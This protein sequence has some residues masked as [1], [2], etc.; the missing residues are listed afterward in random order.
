MATYTLI[1]SYTVGSGGVSD[2]TFSSIPATYTDLYLNISARGSLASAFYGMNLT[3]NGSA[4]SFTGKQLEGSGAAAS[5]ASVTR[6]I[7]THNGNGST[8]STFSNAGVYFTNYASS[9]LNKSYSVDSASETNATT[10][11]VDLQ[12]GL[13]SNTAA[14]TSLSVAM[15]AGNIVEFSSFY[16]YGIK[17]S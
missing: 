16:L 6:N 13:W 10:A 17:N 3:L 15:S 14:I 9:T 7:G 4:S 11:Y 5:S 2:V 1:D 8:A 12:S